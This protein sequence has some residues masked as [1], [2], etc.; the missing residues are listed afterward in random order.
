MNPASSS[1]MNPTSALSSSTSLSPSLPPTLFPY[2]TTYPSL[3]ISINFPSI[4]KK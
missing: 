4:S 1:I 3:S 2:L